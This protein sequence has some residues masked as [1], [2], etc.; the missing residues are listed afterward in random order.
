MS[1]VLPLFVAVV[2]WSFFLALW[3]QHV[4]LGS[5]GALA[6]G[7]VGFAVGPVCRLTPGVQASGFCDVPN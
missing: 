1:P 2:K 3:E 4:E 6:A 5:G 7:H